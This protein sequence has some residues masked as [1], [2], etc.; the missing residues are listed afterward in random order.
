MKIQVGLEFSHL[1]NF[2]SRLIY[3]HIKRVNL[4]SN[5]TMGTRNILRTT[6]HRCLKYAEKFNNVKEGKKTGPEIAYGPTHSYG[7][8]MFELSR[9]HCTSSL[10]FFSLVSFVVSP[11]LLHLLMDIYIR[12]PKVHE[13]DSS[14]TFLPHVQSQNTRK[15]SIN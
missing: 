10:Q 4:C 9:F 13:I 14:R 6:N 3:L 2:T 5:D 7:S 1:R 8:S 11:F 12:L 15:D